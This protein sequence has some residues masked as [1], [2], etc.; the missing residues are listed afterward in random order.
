M[1]GLPLALLAIAVAAWPVGSPATVRLRML[2]G[3]SA[4]RSTGRAPSWSARGGSHVALPAVA[5]ATVA[6]ASAGLLFE[7]RVPVLPAVAGGIAG[8][9]VGFVADR[10]TALRRRQREEAALAELVGALAAD[11]RAG[12]Q[13]A[14]ALAALRAADPRFDLLG[15][16]VGVGAVWT[17]CERSGAPAAA[18]LDRVEEDLRA[19]VHQRREVAAQLAGA[20]STAGLL[21]LLPLLGIG[22]GATMG[23]DP[24]HV[25]LG[26][27]AGQLALVMGVGLDAAGL[28]WT[29]RI[30][31]AAGTDR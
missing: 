7:V 2:I 4:R 25:L 1:T 6:G 16:S 23:A 24:L 18:V 15:R 9:A 11:L 12:Q 30:I 17:I 8:A 26:T 13:P 20:R 22:L 14:H 19:T 28:L 3:R 5:A 21:A 31:A 10:A 29:S 27:P